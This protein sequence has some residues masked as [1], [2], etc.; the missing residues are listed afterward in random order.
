MEMLAQHIEG[1]SSVEVP[2]AGGESD[3][4]KCLKKMGANNETVTSPDAMIKMLRSKRR[5]TP[6]MWANS[7]TRFYL[8]P[9]L[10]SRTQ[11]VKIVDKKDNYRVTDLDHCTS[12]ILADDF[13]LLFDRA[14]GA[15]HYDALLRE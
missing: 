7:A 3:I 4:T 1:N 15:D 5:N 8:G 11:Q 13:V 2:Q 12:T 14:R 10:K 9:F 6:R